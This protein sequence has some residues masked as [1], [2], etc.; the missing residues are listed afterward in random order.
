MRDEQRQRLFDWMISFRYESFSLVE[1]SE[2]QVKP[3]FVCLAFLHV[4]VVKRGKNII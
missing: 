4:I 3:C 1:L 2:A